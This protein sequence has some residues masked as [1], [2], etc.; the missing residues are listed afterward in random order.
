MLAFR[1]KSMA[2]VTNCDSQLSQW[3]LGDNTNTLMIA[4][5]QSPDT[6]SESRRLADDLLP[7]APD[8]FCASGQTIYGGG[9]RAR[10][11][12]YDEKDQTQQLIDLHLV[13]T[14]PMLDGPGEAM[15]TNSNGEM[16]RIAQE[17]IGSSLCWGAEAFIRPLGEL[18]RLAPR[19]RPPGAHALLTVIC[20]KVSRVRSAFTQPVQT[21]PTAN[22]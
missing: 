21:L 6:S 22:S 1:Q 11:I 12:T 9:D 17:L 5:G 20:Q 14:A 13:E 15:Q 10:E 3:A 7:R 8:V 16:A 4:I 2:R 18:K 19:G